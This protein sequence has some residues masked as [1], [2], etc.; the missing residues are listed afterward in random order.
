MALNQSSSTHHTVLI[1]GAGASAHIDYP[2]GL[3]LIRGICDIAGSVRQHPP[4]G[5]TADNVDDFIVRLKEDDPNSID[6]FLARNPDDIQLGKFFI[7]RVLKQYESRDRMTAGRAGWYRSLF[8]AIVD[9]P[10]RGFKYN[11][12][13][14]ITFNYDRSLEAYLHRRCYRQCKLTEAEA[15]LAIEQLNILHLHGTLG[16]Y[17]SVPYDSKATADELVEIATS[18]KII[19][20]LEDR[21][22]TFCTPE[23]R[24]AHEWLV[25]ADRIFFLGF[26]FHPDNMKRFRFFGG[27]DDSPSKNK[28]M[29]ATYHRIGTNHHSQFT[30]SLGHFGMTEGMLRQSPCN[31]FVEEYPIFSWPDGNEPLRG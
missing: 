24:V 25:A 2:L 14:I 20:E 11:R 7:A 4:P 10:S 1:L 17:P 15:D 31:S 30:L 5:H 6:T 26:G 13:K 21:S 22:D 23:F 9:P 3:Q 16:A 18:I 19:T 8:D 29:M 27:A 28:K 12:I